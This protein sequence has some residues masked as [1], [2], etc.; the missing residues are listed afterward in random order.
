M[1]VSNV[2]DW[3]LPFTG[4]ISIIVFTIFYSFSKFREMNAVQANELI[5]TLKEEVLIQKEKNA[6]LTEENRR[7]TDGYQRQIN[8][9]NKEIGELK[10]LYLAA[11]NSKK[12]YLEI[13]QGRSPDQQ[14]FM[15]FLTEAATVSNR[16]QE[17][18]KAYMN[19]TAKA[20]ESI[21]TFMQDLHD[22]NTRVDKQSKFNREEV[23]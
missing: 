16:T 7:L 5:K 13:L 21:L 15:K 8:D 1:N 18:A 4:T 23:K 11:E 22:R 14:K 19:H 9:L 3:L 2:S 12:E 20:L 6:R 10:G 17:E